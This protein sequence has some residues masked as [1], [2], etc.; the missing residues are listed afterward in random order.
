MPWQVQLLPQQPIVETLYAGHLTSEELHAAVT[1]SLQEAKTHRVTRLLSDC[2]TLE[3]GHNFADL[4]DLAENLQ[5][6]DF[7]FSLREAVLLPPTGP[8]VE[9]VKFYETTCRNR[10]LEVRI[11]T[12]RTQA[13]AWLMR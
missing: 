5:N 7:A 11:F 10:G 13:I 6:D 9:M 8:G 12:D 1:A 2:T 4:F 3:G